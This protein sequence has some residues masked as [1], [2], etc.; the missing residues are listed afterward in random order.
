MEQKPLFENLVNG[1]ETAAA[2]LA[3][4]AHWP[5]PAPQLL[6]DDARTAAVVVTLEEG[7]DQ[8]AAL[9]EVRRVAAQHLPAGADMALT[10]TVLEQ[11]AFGSQI[12][13]DRRAFVPLCIVVIVALLVLFHLDLRTLLYS[14]LVMGG[15]L[16]LTESLMA[17]QGTRVHALTALLAPVILIVAVSSTVKACGI[18]NL[19]R[20][21]PQ[22]SL[23]MKFFS[24]NF[25][26]LIFIARKIHT[27]SQHRWVRES[28][29]ESQG[30]V[31][32]SL[33]QNSLSCLKRDYKRHS[34]VL[35]IV[36]MAMFRMDQ[37][38]RAS[39]FRK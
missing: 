23:R 38:Q 11:H 21:T 9:K 8:P 25:W 19:V 24:S 20:N 3:Q 16:T 32:V 27:H 39:I 7:A 6:S 26:E 12:D 17:Q 29:K 31:P 2:F 1:K 18:F 15:S 30:H 14:L 33:K 13:Q 10:G 4:R 22:P 5:P 28:S 34:I 36:T 35:M 37:M